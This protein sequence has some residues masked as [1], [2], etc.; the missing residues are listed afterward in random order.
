MIT[1]SFEGSRPKEIIIKLASI[2]QTSLAEEQEEEETPQ[3]T[4]RSAAAAVY[5]ICS[6]NHSGCRLGPH[7]L[8]PL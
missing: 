7:I 4:S 5:L 1:A 2:Y 6:A 8:G 3:T